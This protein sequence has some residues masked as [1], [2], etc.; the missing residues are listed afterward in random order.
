MSP[1]LATEVP[2]PERGEDRGGV[3]PRL[4]GVLREC[5]YQARCL[6]SPEVATANLDML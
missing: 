6:Q 3:S 2:T 5:A 4:P 1:H